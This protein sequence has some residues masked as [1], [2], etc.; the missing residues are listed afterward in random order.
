MS[1]FF[2]GFDNGGGFILF[3]VFVLLIFGSNNHH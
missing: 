3:L 1:G 2:D